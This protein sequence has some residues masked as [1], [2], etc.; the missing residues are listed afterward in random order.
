M[1]VNHMNPIRHSSGGVDKDKK[2]VPQAQEADQ[3]NKS[4]EVPPAATN[5]DEVVL[6]SEIQPEWLALE[7]RVAQ[8]KS[9]PKGE[10]FLQTMAYY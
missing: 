6:D 4:T 10:R 2:K 3:M 5:S 9:K 8:H 7:R 1:Q